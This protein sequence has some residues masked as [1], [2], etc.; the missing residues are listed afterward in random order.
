MQPYLKLDH[1]DKVFTRGSASTEV[2]KDINLTIDRGRV[3]LDHR[4][5]RLRQVDPAQHRGRSHRPGELTSRF[6]SSTQPIVVSVRPATMLSRVDLPQPECPMI[7][8][9]RP[10]RWSG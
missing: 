5:F 7:R 1:I 8:H 9:T 6:S 4:A 10:D 3:C 2:L